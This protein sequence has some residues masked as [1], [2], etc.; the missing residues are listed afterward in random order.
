ML[1]LLLP[2]IIF[3]LKNIKM[4]YC[5]HF[6]GYPWFNIDY[7]YEKSLTLPS[8]WMLKTWDCNFMS[9]CGTS[10]TRTLHH[11]A[12]ISNPMRFCSTLYS[13]EHCKITQY[14][15]SRNDQHEQKK[16]CALPLMANVILYRLQILWDE[17]GVVRS[18]NMGG[19]VIWQWIWQKVM[20]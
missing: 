16:E 10:L 3:N 5:L 11:D 19:N 13:F 18:I 2:I 9:S 4:R 12:S 1:K 8:N 6:L 14:A 7:T 15:Y 17:L 20:H